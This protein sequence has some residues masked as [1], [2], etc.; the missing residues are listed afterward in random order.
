MDTFKLILLL[1]FLGMA[2]T[3]LTFIGLSKGLRE[4]NPFLGALIEWAGIPTA[5]FF[6]LV[7]M[8]S[9]AILMAELYKQA[10]SLGSLSMWALVLLCALY[11]VVVLNN[12]VQLIRLGLR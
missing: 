4:L 5:L 1:L 6:K 9:V 8:V 10:G 12:I 2:D 7:L 11:G 3:V